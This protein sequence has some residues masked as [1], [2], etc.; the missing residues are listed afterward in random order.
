[1]YGIAGAHGEEWK[2]QVENNMANTCFVAQQRG[3]TGSIGAAGVHGPHPDATV[4]AARRKKGQHRMKA[5]RVNS[6]VRVDNRDAV[7]AGVITV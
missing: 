3:N 1:M 6:G 7:D 4:C 2:I 5:N